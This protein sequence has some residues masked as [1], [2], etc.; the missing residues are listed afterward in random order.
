MHKSIYGLL[1]AGA[2]LLAPATY[3]QEDDS[4]DGLEMDVVE[5]EGTPNEASAKV[6]ALPESASDTARERAQAGLDR[7]NAARADGAGFGA[8]TAEAA[9]EARSGGRGDHG[10]PETTPTGP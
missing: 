1:A 8:D 3:A 5:A 4:L 7:A 2:L 9:R 10:R 6:L